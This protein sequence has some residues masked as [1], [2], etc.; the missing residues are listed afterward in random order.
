[1]TYLMIFRLKQDLNTQFC[2]FFAHQNAAK[3]HHLLIETDATSV[4]GNIS[5]S[6]IPYP[7]WL[8]KDPTKPFHTSPPRGTFLLLA[9]SKK[10]G[11]R[12]KLIVGILTR[13]KQHPSTQ[14]DLTDNSPP[15][16]SDFMKTYPSSYG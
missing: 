4:S 6:V 15:L 8:H 16:C 3:I 7:S 14:S 1:M 10:R 5:R 2:N 9:G 11:F 13:Q 12:S